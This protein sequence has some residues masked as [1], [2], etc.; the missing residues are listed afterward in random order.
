MV[1]RM[2]LVQHPLQVELDGAGVELSAVVEAHV[3]AQVEG[4]TSPV[5]AD[6]PAPRQRGLGLQRAVTA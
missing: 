4:V 5:V 2:V 1:K 6:L 3:P